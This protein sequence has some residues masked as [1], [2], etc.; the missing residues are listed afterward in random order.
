[1]YHRILLKLSGEAL[2]DDNGAVIFSEKNF[3]EMAKAI[4]ALHENGTQ[5]GIVIGGGN[6][7]RG[8]LAE[9]LSLERVPADFMGM[10]GT[11]INCVSMASAL[12]NMGVKA[13]VYSALGD[14]PDGVA[15]MYD[16]EK[17]IK[18]MENG[19][20]VFFAGGTG[21]PY[22]STDTA[23]A[24]RAL[25][26]GCEAILMAK[27]GVD[28]VY[29]KDPLKYSDAKFFKDITYQQVL[30]LKLGVMDLSAVEL[31]KDTDLQIRVFSMQDASNVIRVSNGEDIGT[32]V[33]R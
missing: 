13:T 25:E 2:K 11:V 21:K 29:D 17:A 12:H 26:T 20:V 8:K 6:I 19:E 18:S 28:G 4:K 23:A 9:T 16:K 3:L 5:I 1:M 22:F 30:D 27:H 31:I 24:I 7:W 15:K 10:L 33:R 32:T 14:L